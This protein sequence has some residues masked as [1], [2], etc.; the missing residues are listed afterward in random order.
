MFFLF[1]F[2]HEAAM[3]YIIAI[4][5]KGTHSSLFLFVCSSLSPKGF[6]SHHFKL[7]NGFSFANLSSDLMKSQLNLLGDRINRLLFLTYNE[8]AAVYEKVVWPLAFHGTL[9]ISPL[10][11]QSEER[12]YHIA[13]ETRLRTPR[14]HRPLWSACT[15]FFTC[16][17]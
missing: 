2:V 12:I 6:P 16:I 4:Y 17:L 10:N 1:L 15:W 9:Y 7:V 14:L 8:R 5:L 11:T 13:N 3:L